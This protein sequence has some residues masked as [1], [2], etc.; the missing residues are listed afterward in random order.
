MT[1]KSSNRS[2]AFMTAIILITVLLVAVWEYT[3]TVAQNL[4]LSYNMVKEVQAI[5]IAR[6][7]FRGALAILKMDSDSEDGMH[8]Q[9]RAL[10]PPMIPLGTGTA[11][12]E[13]FAEDSKLNVNHLVNDYDS[14]MN[15]TIH[16]YLTELFIML[17]YD[18][19]KVFAIIDFIDKDSITSA[20]GA[21]ADYYERLKPPITIKNSSL[22]S[23]YELATIKGITIPMLKG[24]IKNKELADKMKDQEIPYST[25][26]LDYLTVYG[27]YAKDKSGKTR[28]F[29]SLNLNFIPL[30]LLKAMDQDLS[31]FTLKRIHED[32]ESG[33]FTQKDISNQDL[34]I[35]NYGMS[36]NTYNY[37]FGTEDGDP[38]ITVKSKF[39][40]IRGVGEVDN[41][42]KI[43]EAVVKRESKQFKIL[44]YS[45]K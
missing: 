39:F 38:R 29:G 10:M 18:M 42:T 11:K 37:L 41:I 34:M 13:V 44:F 3:Y 24:T 2:F 17:G 28:N 14:E 35:T 6:A 16:S 23:I 19:N 36:I 32:R 4:R 5:S 12:L 1:K 45:E 30:L 43:V 8:D 40:R 27:D 33:N 9:W 7:S 20:Y 21:E 26:L 15:T 31:D 22:D 25:A